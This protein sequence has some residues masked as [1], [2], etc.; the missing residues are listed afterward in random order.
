MSHNTIEE[1]L[2]VVNV[3]INFLNS[4]KSSVNYNTK[5]NFINGSVSLG[6]F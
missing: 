1:N 2:V 6:I 5:R 4:V 3:K